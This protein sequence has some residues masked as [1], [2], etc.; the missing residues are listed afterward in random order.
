[1]MIFL[2]WLFIFITLWMATDKDDNDRWKP[3]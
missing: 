1:M 3:S 2:L